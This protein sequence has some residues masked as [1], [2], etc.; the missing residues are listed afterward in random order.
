MSAD[1]KPAF[2]QYIP[3]ETQTRSSHKWLPRATALALTTLVIACTPLANTNKAATTPRLEAPSSTTV[4]SPDAGALIIPT[5]N[6]P[7]IPGHDLPGIPPTFEREDL[8]VKIQ[9]F[10]PYGETQPSE[11]TLVYTFKPNTQRASVP[12]YDELKK[13]LFLFKMN[14][15]PRY[16]PGV[17]IAGGMGFAN[18]LQ[19]RL[20]WDS[21]ITTVDFRKSNTYRLMWEK[22]W[23]LKGSTWNGVPLPVKQP[24]SN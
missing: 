12:S 3:V 2:I 13:N 16:Q 20:A 23:K 24:N 11:G 9:F 18:E 10:L 8:D 6:P 4:P 21:L 19:T 7:I 14:I 15:D 1:L 17:R 5:V 22:D